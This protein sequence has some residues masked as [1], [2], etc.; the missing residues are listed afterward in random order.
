MNDTPEKNNDLAPAPA[1]PAESAPSRG[2]FPDGAAAPSAAE[3]S[4][5]ASQDEAP[6]A[7]NP[8][9]KK[10]WFG[11]GIYGSKDV[12]IRIL[13]GIIAAMI[14]AAVVLTIWGAAHNGFSITFNTGVDDITVPAQTV[15]HGELV[16][17]P[18]APLRPGYNL[19]G[20]STTPDPEVNL[21]DFDSYEV[22]GDFTL[23]AVWE[24]ASFPVRFDLDGGTV[25]GWSEVDP[26]TVTYGQAYGALPVP[27]KEGAVFA[28]W[29][30]SGQIITEDSTVTMTGEHVLTA[31]WE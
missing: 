30:Y 21:W 6:P 17:E 12:P 20:W 8:M 11:R 4:S 18:E 3:G 2:D 10:R 1:A 7:E 13:D 31:L 19:V 22:E 5:P 28:G 25:D 14:V 23:Y 15:L 24:P 16:T 9:I 26:I 27:E 29:M